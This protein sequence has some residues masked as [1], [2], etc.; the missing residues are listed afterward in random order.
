MRVLQ[1]AHFDVGSEVFTPDEI[2]AA[3][4]LEPTRVTRRGSRSTDPG[5]PALERVAVCGPG[6]R[7]RR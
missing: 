1:Y 7:L 6:R 4:N 3:L 2:T 5:D